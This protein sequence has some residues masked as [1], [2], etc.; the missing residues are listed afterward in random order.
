[1]GDKE[2]S[3]RLETAL[4]LFDDGVDL[5][6]CRIRRERPGASAPEI[7]EAIREWLR[8]DLSHVTGASAPF[9]RL[10]KPAIERR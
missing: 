5:M 1:M 8:G 4:S 6:R 2:A 7:D 10:R 3:A 9:F